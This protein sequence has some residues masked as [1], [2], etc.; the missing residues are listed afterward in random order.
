MSLTNLSTGELMV[1]QYNPQELEETLSVNWNELSVLGMS[2]K[3]LQYQNT[4]NHAFKFKLE[5]SAINAMGQKVAPSIA[6]ENFNGQTYVLNAR[7]YLLSLCYPS[8]G[9]NTIIGGG[10][11]RVLFY[12]PQSVA[13]DAVIGELSLHHKSF[14][15]RLG[16]SRLEVDVSLREIR[17]VRLVS[18]DVREYGTSRSVSVDSIGNARSASEV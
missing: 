15:H 2:H 5:F 6:V 3:P 1:A 14:N 13:I 12:W 18:E 17:D 9:A 4:G 8:R 7:N 16:T 10:P 11:P